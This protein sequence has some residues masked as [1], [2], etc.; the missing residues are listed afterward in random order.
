MHKIYNLILVQ[1]N[2]QL[3]EN[4]ASNAKLQAVK[5]GRESIGH[6]M[7]LNKVSV[8][9]KSKQHFIC[10]LCLAMRKLYNTMKHARDNTT[11]Y[12]VRLRNTQKANR[13]C[14]GILITRASKSMV[15]KLSFHY[16]PLNLTDY[17]TMERRRRIHQERKCSAQS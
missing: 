9:N 4:A 3:Q 16:I 1:I 12:L 11:N 10:S 6:L 5:T 17:S 15:C 14:N 8:S 2:Q 13:V 7:I